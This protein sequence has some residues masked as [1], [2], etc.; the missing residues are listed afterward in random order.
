LTDQ[1]LDLIKQVDKEH[2]NSA[3][4]MNIGANYLELAQDD[5]KRGDKASAKE[6]LDNVTAL[7]PYLS[8]GDKQLLNGPYSALQTRLGMQ[9]R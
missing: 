1:A 2:A 4:C 9:A 8:P 5:L 7:L 3:L 6:A